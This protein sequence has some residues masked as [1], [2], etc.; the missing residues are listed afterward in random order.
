MT[1]SI[2][3]MAISRF[4]IRYATNTETTWAVIA[5]F[6]SINNNLRFFVCDNDSKLKF[7]VKLSIE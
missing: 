3:M 7:M 1:K 5:I 6:L 2:G 4:K